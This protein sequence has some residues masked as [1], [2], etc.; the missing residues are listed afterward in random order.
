MP[1]SMLPEL[2][3][4]LQQELFLVRQDIL[5]YLQRAPANEFRSLIAEL[6]D[7][8]L[9]HW[10]EMLRSCLTPELDAKNRRLEQLQAALSQMDMGLYG[11]CCDCD[12][13]IERELLTADPARQ[14]CQR[15]EA[16]R[17]EARHHPMHH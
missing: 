8:A 10:P 7:R 17:V 6:E 12:A 13:R 14:R 2:R 9:S 4:R 3:D 15:C 16:K 1:K 11:L 5:L